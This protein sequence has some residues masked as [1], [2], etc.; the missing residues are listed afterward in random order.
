MN[1]KILFTKRPNLF[2]KRTKFIYQNSNFYL[3]PKPIYFYVFQFIYAKIYL[4]CQILLF[5]YIFLF[6]RFENSCGFDKNKDA[7]PKRFKS[8][9][10]IVN[11]R[12]ENFNS[13]F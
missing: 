1:V 8:S 5:I 10:R 11:L 12:N 9:E 3:C 2:T 7:S 6:I 4:F 13:H